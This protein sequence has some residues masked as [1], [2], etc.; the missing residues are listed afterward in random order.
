MNKRVI[1]YD[2]SNKEF[3]LIQNISFS[4]FIYIYTNLLEFEL[5]LYDLNTC[6]NEQK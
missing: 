5:F 6:F 1:L 2:L 4:L 3:Y